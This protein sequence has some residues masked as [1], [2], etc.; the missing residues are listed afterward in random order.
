MDAHRHCGTTKLFDGQRENDSLGRVLSLLALRALAFVSQSSIPCG[1]YEYR[2]RAKHA[3]RASRSG[4]AYRHAG[5]AR[6]LGLLSA[7]SA[8]RFDVVLVVSNIRL[9]HGAV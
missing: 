8:A 3:G 2:Q 5:K 1:E 7:R 9:L 4:L 6:N